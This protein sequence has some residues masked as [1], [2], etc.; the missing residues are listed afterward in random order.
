[1]GGDFAWFIMIILERG[2]VGHVL[3]LPLQSLHP[4]L[5]HS[6]E[7]SSREALVRTQ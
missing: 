7:Q 4:F 2:D 1:M 6:V 3:T 5:S